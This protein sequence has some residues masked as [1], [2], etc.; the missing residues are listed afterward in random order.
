MKKRILFVC[1]AFVLLAGCNGG[2]GKG[3]KATVSSIDYA[4]VETPAFDADSA[5]AFVAAQVAC[6]HRT[7]GSEGQRR[8][9]DYLAQQ[10]RRWCD[11]VIVQDFPAVLWDGTEVRGKNIIATVNAREGAPEIGRVLLAAHWDS[12]MWADHDPDKANH[13]KPFDGANDGASGVGVLHP[14]LSPSP[15]APNPSQHQNLFQ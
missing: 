3:S 12:R 8:C 15:P 9:A 5:Y 2:S 1:V 13:H 6:G 14:L 4:K 11:T 10:M 7:P